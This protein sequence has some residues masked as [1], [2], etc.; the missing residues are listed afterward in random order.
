MRLLWFNLAT[1]TDDPVLA[2]T[3]SW[4]RAVASQVEFIHVITM[5]AGHVEAPNNVRVYSVGKERGFS[6]ARR[7]IEFYRTLWNILRTDHVQACFSHMI[8]VF[9]VM[10]A[11]IL[12]AAG[13]PIV[14]WFAHRRRTTMLKAAHLVSGRMATSFRAA[15]PYGGD[16]VI[17]LGQGIDTSLFAPR[18]VEREANPPVILSAGRLAPVKNLRTFLHAAAHLRELWP[19]PFH[20]VV[21]GSPA[22]HLDRPYAN[23]LLAERDAIG[24]REVIQFE[25]AVRHEALPIWYR[26]SA[27]HVNL[28]DTGSGDKTALEAMACGRPCIVTNEG[29]EETLGKHGSLL[30]AR[31]ND[32][33]D[34]ARRLHS[35]LSGSARQ[36][37]EI[38]AYLRAQVERDHSLAALAGKLVQVLESVAAGRISEARGPA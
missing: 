26:R 20:A 3:S 2:F 32:P 22:T 12:H 34:I 10:A 33:N 36:R 7:A 19:H 31:S 14:T 37:A 8:P 35:L 38:G 23:A 17:V 15:Y 6:N 4:I 25:P 27:V 28:T 5:R 29:F 21:L 24:L 18:P 9:T 11:P 16:K 1:D 13:I 30:L